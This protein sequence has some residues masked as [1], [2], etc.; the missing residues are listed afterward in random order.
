MKT[1]SQKF[2][3]IKV[4]YRECILKC[5]AQDLIHAEWTLVKKFGN[6]LMLLDSRLFITPDQFWPNYFLCF[7]I[8]GISEFIFSSQYFLTFDL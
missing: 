2:S 8:I 3:N 4:M 5:D 7:G 1:D 6:G